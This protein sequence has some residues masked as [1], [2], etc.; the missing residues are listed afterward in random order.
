MTARPQLTALVITAFRGSTGTLR[1]DFDKKKKLAL[2]YGEN[3]T[4]KTTICDAFEFLARGEI[5][6]LKDRGIGSGLAKYWPS[7]GRS[8]GD[9]SVTLT[10]EA[11]ACAGTIAASKVVV[12]PIR[13]R[14]RVEILRRGMLLKLIEATP[15]GRYEEIKRFID[16]SAYEQS[17]DALK[18]QLLALRR[19]KDA[20]AAEET[21]YLVQLNDFY[22]HDGK[23]AGV[24]AVTWAEGRLAE[25]TTDATADIKAV[26]QLRLAY[27]TLTSF[28]DLFATAGTADDRAEKAVANAES[29]EQALAGD[30]SGP[31][32][33]ALLQAGQQLLADHAIVA[34]C[35]L[36][37]SR[38]RI[39][40]LRDAIE[41][42]L[43]RLET[44]RQASDDRRRAQTA[45]QGTRAR[46]ADLRAAYASAVATF[47]ERLAGREWPVEVVRPGEPAPTD[48]SRLQNWL[49]TAD[50]ASQSWSSAETT[51]RNRAN[52]RIML[53][54]AFDR[55]TAAAEKREEWAAL[56][57]RLDAAS[58]IL[59]AERQMFVDGII[60]DIA[61][62]VGDLYE[63]IHPGE[64]LNKIAMP[65]DPKQ[66][67]SLLL[68]AE[69]AGQDAPPAAYF[70]Q[71][72]LDTLGLCVFLALAL[73]E[74][75]DDTI[76]ILD[77]VLGSIDEPHVDRVV[78][79]IYAVSQRFRHAIVTTH[80]RPWREKYRWGFVKPGQE[81]QFV[82]LTG[83]AIK[84]GM[85]LS[86]T[87]PETERLKDL[88]THS[89]VDTQAVCG[90]AGVILEAAL[91]HL[92]LKYGCAVPRKIGEAYTVSD[93]L[94]NINGK[95]RKA[96]RAE[97]CEDG[98]VVASTELGPILDELTRIAQARNVFG[99]H[100]KEITFELMDADAIGFAQQVVALADALVCPTYGWPGSNK[101][102]SYW[103][104]SGDTRRLH[105][106]Q[107]PS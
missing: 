58:K 8:P 45:V 102:G 77:D 100:F 90:K 50:V 29:A 51:W 75:A 96:L 20:L 52:S 69:F 25:A 107:K 16:I 47:N 85:R 49:A 81:C 43:A 48:I 94:P 83:W 19:E 5:G 38:E 106:L 24:N 61:K 7:A 2:I 6:S 34:E 66:R 35:P 97:I 55:Y 13:D 17:E 101:S 73:R 14:P 95:L 28:P 59:V 30:G 62:T 36:C 60:T 41:R 104:N 3:G 32:L 67:A 31:E 91:D 88:L 105:P 103:R 74:R 82:E 42:R 53:R 57:P 10:T 37:E 68:R 46:L 4:G 80:Y 1:I 89:P 40:G 86:S 63:R 98:V 64:G 9:V 56:E 78:E 39:A 11:G 44:M 22:E 72:H 87:R 79:M 71:S 93:L 99:A 15:G 26:E 65:L 12:A 33:V 23:Q 27:L 18:S 76:L 70:S 54:K 21:Q 92:T 84:D